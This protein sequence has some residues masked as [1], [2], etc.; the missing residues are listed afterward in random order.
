MTELGARVA[1]PLVVTPEYLVTSVIDG[2]TF[3]I[4]VNEEKQTVRLIAV[5]APE[6]RHP[7]KPVQCFSTEAKKYLKEL[8]ENKYV[9]LDKE[10]LDSDKDR[11]GR[12]L[13]YAFINGKNINEL[14]LR[15]GY[16]LEK[17]YVRGYKYQSI[18]KKAQNYAK[19]YSLGLWSES[20]CGGNVNF[21]TYLDIENSELEYMHG[22]D[23]AKTCS[24][25]KTCKEAMFQFEVCKCAGRDLDGDG[26]PC[27]NL[28]I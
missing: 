26:A 1:K 20:T 25:I 21:N 24:D 19:T 16:A 11:Y 17:S 6:S 9:T 7:T 27:S 13:R 15:N 4:L 28:C 2:D 18:F 23:C 14:L 8:I 3:D 22:C 12:L 10:I 5:D